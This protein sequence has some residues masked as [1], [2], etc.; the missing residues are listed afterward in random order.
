MIDTNQ[1]KVEKIMIKSKRVSAE[2]SH[3]NYAYDVIDIIVKSQH[4][5]VVH[6]IFGAQ[7]HHVE[8]KQRLN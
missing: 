8:I 2:E 4:G 1:H 7:D 5:T 3:G 6:T